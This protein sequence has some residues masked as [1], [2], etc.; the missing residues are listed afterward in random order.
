MPHTSGTPDR[1][2]HNDSGGSGGGSVTID[3]QPIDVDV[4]T[5]PGLTD[6]ELRATPV[7]VVTQEPISVDDNGSS[8][9]VDGA[10]TVTGP[11]ADGN[12]VSGNPVIVAGKDVFGDA[13]TIRTDALG[14]LQP[15]A[16]NTVLTDDVSN[17]N[18]GPFGGNGGDRLYYPS[19]GYM[20]DGTDWDRVRGDSANGMLVNL[21]ANNDVT[22]SDG[23]GSL[24]VDGAVSVTGPAADGAPV[25]GNPVRIA[26]K[27][28]S[29]NTQDIVTD[30]NGLLLPSAN[31]TALADDVS[32]TIAGPFGGTGNNR[33]YYPSFGYVFDGTSWDRQRGDSTDGTLVNLGANNDVTVTGTVSVTEPVSVDDNGGS[34]T[35]DSLA[36]KVEDTPHATGDTGIFFLGVRNDRSATTFANVDGDYSPISVNPQGRV[37]VERRTASDTLADG[38]TNSRRFAAGTNESS[39]TNDLI[40]ERVFPY[41]FNGS[42]W[43]RLR[44]D[45]NGLD[46]NVNNPGLTDAEL[47]A[48]PVPI[49]GTVT[50]NL[51]TIDGAATE[52][53]LDTRTGSLTETAPATDTA[54][55]G[56]N[57]RLQ[58]IAQRI[59][60]LIA[61]LPASLGQKTKANSL[62]VTLASDTDT[63][64]TTV[65]ATS[66]TLAN[67]AETAV[68]TSATSVLAS[69]ANRKGAI[70]Q[71]VGTGIVRVGVTGVTATTGIRLLP[72]GHLRLTSPYCPDE[73]I[74]AI[75]EAAT[76]TST[77]LAQEST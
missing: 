38:I 51:G 50:A 21:G 17:N 62:A 7:P 16:N 24:T 19:L 6:A 66:G 20:F 30:T 3:G 8:L 36:E 47:R 49:S 77:V 57:G 31:N 67:G 48:T 54:S 40:D 32:N 53:T 23:G 2:V 5:T 75:C 41:V 43:D 65:T 52:A 11:D 63:L 64:A 15:S 68:T 73:A 37:W 14:L 45:T 76:P 9:T 61:L 10:V 39:G 59:T 25:S 33:L 4:I 13:R 34:L 74:F 44:G 27:D 29:G 58:R 71:N 18:V 60:S 56:I 46:V 70:I 69:N 26:G 42:T 22:V 28:G 35:V 72:G 55:S 12:P 1:V